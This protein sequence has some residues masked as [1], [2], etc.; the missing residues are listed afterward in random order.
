MPYLAKA[1][2]N[3]FLELARQENKPLTQMQIQKLVYISHGFNLALMNG[4]PLI[5][6]DI[7]AWQYGPVI[8]SLYDEFRGFGNQP[9]TS[10]ATITTIDDNFNINST[11][12]HITDGQTS[13]LISAVW[14]KYKIYSGPNLSDLTHKEGTP[15]SITLQNNSFR[16]TINNEVIKDYYNQLLV[17]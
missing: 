4:E 9:I 8:S 14:D 13:E 5:D 16:S 12:P 17:G 7:Q 11:V 1:V 2:A 6:E 3:K 10:D 15:W